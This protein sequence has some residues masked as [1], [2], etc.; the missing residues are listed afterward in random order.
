M[1]ALC[2]YHIC[3]EIPTQYQQ[4]HP[5]PLSGWGSAV[6]R[7]RFASTEAK[8]GLEIPYN[9]TACDCVGREKQPRQ[10]SI[11]YYGNKVI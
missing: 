6:L 8:T 4:K 2:I 10:I 7:V 5:T 11:Y 1:C 9:H 3:G